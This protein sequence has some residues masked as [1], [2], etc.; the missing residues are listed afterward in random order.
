[1]RRNSR[2]PQAREGRSPGWKLFSSWSP[3]YVPSRTRTRKCEA[4]ASLLPSRQKSQPTVVS[5]Y[6][7]W[8]KWWGS[9]SPP[10]QRG[11][12]ADL[13]P[14]SMGG[15]SWAR[16]LRLYMGVFMKI[17]M[18]GWGREESKSD[19]TET[20]E[21][22]CHCETVR[23]ASDSG[24]I[25]PPVILW[26]R[27]AHYLCVGITWELLKKS[28]WPGSSRSWFP[29]GLQGETWA[30]MLLKAPQITPVGRQG[31]V[32]HRGKTAESVMRT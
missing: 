16:A 25:S 30:S 17:R 24:R 5:C 12:P 8:H 26:N 1:M 31:W 18:Q 19:P 32:S 6:H 9:G 23:W 2:R 3:G 22:F 13:F 4:P 29:K 15:S 10:R 27:D 20:S 14:A 28:Q 11:A 21:Q 7:S